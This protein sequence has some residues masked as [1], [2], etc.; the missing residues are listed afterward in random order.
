VILYRWDEWQT[1]WGLILP[2]A[3]GYSSLGALVGLVVAVL[4]FF[5]APEGG[6]RWDDLDHTVVALLLGVGI[7]RIGCFLGHHHAGRLSQFILAVRYPGGPRHDL[8]LCEALLVFGIL[9]AVLVLE[10]HLSRWRAGMLCGG[11]TLAYAV[12]RFALE[13][14]RG[15]DIERL[16]RHS[17][18]RYAGLTLIQ[19]ATILLAVSALGV[20]TMRARGRLDGNGTS[21]RQP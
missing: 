6:L 5:R 2:W 9:V 3:G 21:A 14:L 8:G 1:D 19:Y 18:P 15:S 11:I 10:R 7:L 17:D 13:F 20:L 16:G 4:L 12:G